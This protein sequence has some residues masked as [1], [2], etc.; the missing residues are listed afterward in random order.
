MFSGFPPD[1]FK[2][3]GELEQN[4]N[5]DWWAEN[6]WKY[7]EE[8]LPMVRSFIDA[9]DPIW[10]PMIVYRP[11]RQVR[12]S[13]NKDPYKTV[14]GI[15]GADP[16]G[17]LHYIQLSGNGILV[18]RGTHLFSPDQQLRYYE[19]IDQDGDYEFQA[20]M[21]HCRESG[22]EVGGWQKL[23]TAPKGYSR[24]HLRVELLRYGGIDVSKTW[25]P[26]DESVSTAQIVKD[27]ESAWSLAEPVTSWLA[28][29]VG[30]PDL[31]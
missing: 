23:I 1:V 16:D 19:A 9:L 5:R 31:S 18:A 26:D 27:V 30:P 28:Q 6:G 15:I 10:Q 2:F 20:R 14:C 11:Y 25:S 12:F 24:Q 8:I 17:S 3:Y 13:P 7:K 29:H 4:N 22:L 21:E